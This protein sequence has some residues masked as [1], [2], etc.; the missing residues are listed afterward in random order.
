[1][2]HN[3]ISSF[4]H[5]FIIIHHLPRPPRC[6]SPPPLP[7]SIMD[8][9]ILKAQWPIF[10]LL[11]I[12]LLYIYKCAC[13]LA[14][15]K[16]TDLHL[17]CYV[18]G[19]PKA[20]K[21]QS[22]QARPRPIC[23]KRA[24]WW[25][26]VGAIPRHKRVAVADDCSQRKAEKRAAGQPKNQEQQHR[27]PRPLHVLNRHG[28]RPVHHKQRAVVPI[29]NPHQRHQEVRHPIR[30]E[31]WHSTVDEVIRAAA[32]FDVAEQEQRDEC[33]TGKHRDPHVLPVLKAWPLHHPCERTWRNTIMR[34]RN[35]RTSAY[36]RQLATAPRGHCREDT[37]GVP[38]SPSSVPSSE[39]ICIYIYI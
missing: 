21:P 23:R 18:V 26:L 22:H 13:V 35:M 32:E 36:T 25:R 16:R 8:E 7:A 11:L 15:A 5:H 6:L 31:K 37:A 33:G 10:R 30:R 27:A 3:Y 20:V 34:H 4:H 9:T 2:I 19:R 14:H 1:M 28:A 12:I 29:T 17:I 39:Y 38:P 24:V